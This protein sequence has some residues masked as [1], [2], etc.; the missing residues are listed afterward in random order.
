MKQEPTDALTSFL[1]AGDRPI[2]F[3]LGSAAVAVADDYF[4]AAAAASRKLGRRAILIYGREYESNVRGIE[5]RDDLLLVPYAPF[6]TVFSRASVIVHQGGVGTCA[7]TLRAGRPCLV[8]P[9]S[10]D[11]F[12]N[13]ARLRRLGVADVIHR[14]KLNDRTLADKLRGILSNSVMSRRAQEC[15]AILATENGAE[16]ACTAIESLNSVSY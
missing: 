12:D 9:F 11:Q 2:V 16:A 5:P 7:Q 1:D 14:H 3:T 8:V 4:R 10:H 13:A 6:S 15:S